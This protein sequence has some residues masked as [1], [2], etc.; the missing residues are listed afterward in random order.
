MI[1]LIT[2]KPTIIINI[3]GDRMVYLGKTRV[4]VF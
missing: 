1:K 3:I 4:F 2:E